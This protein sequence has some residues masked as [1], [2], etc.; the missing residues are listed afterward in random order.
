MGIRIAL[1]AGP[2]DIQRL[3]V[4]EG[5]LPVVT[6]LIVGLFVS[7]WVGS[8]LAASLFAVRPG[9]PVVLGAATLTLLLATLAACVRP[10]LRA[11]RISPAGALRA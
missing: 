1:G 8:A 2:R 3:V 6:G 7:G 11:T 10:A 4:A 9:D 5:V